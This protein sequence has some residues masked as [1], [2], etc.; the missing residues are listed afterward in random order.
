MRSTSDTYVPVKESYEE[1][2]PTVKEGAA[3]PAYNSPDIQS[4]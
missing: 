1:E 3:V 4:H 2:I